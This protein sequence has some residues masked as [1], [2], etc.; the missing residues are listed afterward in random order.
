MAAQDPVESIETEVN[1]AV[2]S[3][4]AMFDAALWTKEDQ[5]STVVANTINVA[6]LKDQYLSDTANTSELLAEYGFDDANSSSVRNSSIEL[7]EG[8]SGAWD[9]VAGTFTPSWDIAFSDQ[10]VYF[11]LTFDVADPLDTT[12]TLSGLTKEILLRSQF[13]TRRPPLST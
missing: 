12:F 5:S 4:A 9:S 13:D 10:D 7:A 1:T 2:T 6:D 3:N 11:I 8:Q